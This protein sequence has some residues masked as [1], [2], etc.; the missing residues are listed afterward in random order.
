MGIRPGHI[1]LPYKGKK[2]FLFGCMLGIIVFFLVHFPS[3]ILANTNQ[4]PAPKNNILQQEEI[5]ALEKTIH[6][7]SD[8]KARKNIIAD[9]KTLLDAKKSL[10]QKTEAVSVKPEKQTINLIHLYERVSN[11]LRAAFISFKK[12]FSSLPAGYAQIKLFFSKKENL[13]K[14]LDIGVKFFIFMGISFFFLFFFGKLV[15]RWRETYQK[16]KTFSFLGKIE[17]LLSNIF[18]ESYHLA[19]LFF[20]S[21]LF[22]KSILQHLLASSII[23]ALGAWFVYLVIKNLVRLLLFPVDSRDRLFQLDEQL[24]NY[25]LIWCNRVLLFSLWLFI[26]GKPFSLYGFKQV[27]TILQSIYRIG[28]L[29]MLVIILA[30]WKGGIKKKITLTVKEGDAV[31]KVKYKSIFNQLAGTLIFILILYLSAIVLTYV[32]GYKKM[33]Q[34]FLYATLKSI[35][36]IGA[37]IF[38]SFLWGAVFRKLFAVSAEIKSRYPSSEE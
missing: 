7:L 19:I 26:L 5:S 25:I 30:Q 12:T 32:L 10:A 28:L 14:L 16:K 21:W 13:Y 38:V 29:V 6:I 35:L 36:L 2:V 27:S 3:S 37:A 15:R 24:A 23:Y 1:L 20:L 9:L 8:E 17:T 34:F 22:L 31:W 18:L 4:E 33:Y 11:K